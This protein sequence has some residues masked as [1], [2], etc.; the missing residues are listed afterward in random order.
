[1]A[2]DAT[3]QVLD[4]ALAWGSDLLI[5]HHPLLFHPI[6]RVTDEDFIGRR[7]VRLLQKDVS[8]IA[9]HTNYDVCSMADLAADRLGLEN[10]QVL[11]ETWVPEGAAEEPLGIGKIGLLKE[12]L[13]L[14]ALCRRIKEAFALEGLR[15]FGDRDRRVLRVAVCP[16]S[17]KSVIEE[18][19]A[20]GAQVLVT[21]DIGHHEGIDAW[22]RGM[23]VVDAGH[24]GLEHIFLE[25]MKA[26]LAQW[27]PSLSVE[28]ERREHPYHSL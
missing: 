4:H 28:A 10:Q 21:G 9:L 24:Y 15:L 6:K 16:G 3:D 2:V 20:K 25:D 26:R 19:L 11:E 22:A 23:A 5:T 14:E 7:L 8:Y 13:P 17:G 12:P 18:A 27:F 1:M